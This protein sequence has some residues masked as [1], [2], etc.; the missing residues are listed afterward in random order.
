MRDISL[1]YF[2]GGAG[3]VLL[4]CEGVLVLVEI[5]VFDCVFGIAVIDVVFIVVFTL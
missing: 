4:K 1:F 3:N 2:G 5:R